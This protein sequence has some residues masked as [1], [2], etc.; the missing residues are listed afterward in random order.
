[1]TIALDWLVIVHATALCAAPWSIPYARL[2]PRRRPQ[3]WGASSPSFSSTTPTSQRCWSSRTPPTGGTGAGRCASGRPCCQGRLDEM[4]CASGPTPGCF[5]DGLCSLRLTCPPRCARCARCARSL[6]MEILRG[7]FK[8]GLEGLLARTRVQGI[9]LGTRRCEPKPH[10]AANCCPNSVLPPSAQFALCD[11]AAP[12]A[13]WLPPLSLA[14]P[15]VLLGPLNPTHPSI[16][17]L[18]M[19]CLAGATPMPRTRRR[20]APAA[21]AG[22]PSCG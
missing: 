10:T 4:R 12:V 9:I 21:P 16:F 7:D 15:T 11:A 8:Q 20:S 17:C 2:P 6:G 19:V 5:V 18:S 22:R 13:D 14:A 1:V 3:R